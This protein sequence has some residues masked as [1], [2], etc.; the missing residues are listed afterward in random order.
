MRVF[1]R[2]FLHLLAGVAA[3]PAT[4]HFAGA[5]VSPTSS[6][7]VRVATGLLAIWQSTAW[8]GAETGIF[9]KRGIDMTLPA[10]AVG[11]PEAT[12][13][14]IR[15]DWEFAHTGTVPVAEE[16]LKGRD[17]VILATPTLDFPK[18][19]VMTRKEITQL[20]QLAGKKVGV[21]TETGQTSVAARIT[22]E[23]AGATATYLPLVKFDRIYAALVAEEIDAGALPIDLRFSGQLR[24]GWNAFPIDAFDTPSI[25]AT[26]RS[27]IASNRELVM[28]VMQGFV[29]TIHLF[30]T[31]PDIVVP[32]LQRY[33]KIEDRK[34]AEDLYA[35]HVPVFQKVPRPSFPGMQELRDFLVTRYPTAMS[36]EEAD[37]ADSSFVDELQR[38]G[39]IDRLY[40]ADTK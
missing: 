7:R 26:T 11:G 37:I 15:G 23:K 16:V 25:F 27:L 3:L 29:E 35:F 12:A 17:V 39:F 40:A 28:K 22:V 32:L 10:I 38:S 1:R 20:A 30:K 9:K 8:L 13:G 2:K 36:L 14:L 4:S 6:Q 24:Y 5:Q 33:V 31:R 19:F 34:V 18:S 21:L